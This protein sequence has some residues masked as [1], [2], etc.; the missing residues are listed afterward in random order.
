MGAHLHFELHTGADAN[1]NQGE[2]VNPEQ[3]FDNVTQAPTSVQNQNETAAYSTYNNITSLSSANEIVTSCYNFFTQQ[4]KFNKCAACAILGVIQYKSKFKLS[5]TGLMD[6]ST[7]NGLQSYCMANRYE[8]NSVAGQLG[9]MYSELQVDKSKALS[10]ITLANNSK[11]NVSATAKSFKMAWDN[12][13]AL[14]MSDVTNQ[15]G[16]YAEEWWEYFD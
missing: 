5:G 16:T 11:D 13:E 1:D 7:L 8:T 6:W 4:L 9:Y 15:C 3:L 2:A 14:T 10:I 12:E